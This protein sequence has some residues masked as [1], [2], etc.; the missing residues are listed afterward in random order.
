MELNTNYVGNN[1]IQL[2]FYQRINSFIAVSLSQNTDLISKIECRISCTWS[3][4][5]ILNRQRLFY[6]NYISH[7]T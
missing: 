6:L 1:I 7:K 5:N 2:A 4:S 3:R